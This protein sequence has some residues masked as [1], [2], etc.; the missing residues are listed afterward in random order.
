[1]KFSMAGILA[2]A[3]VL[4]AISPASAQTATPTP[5]LQEVDYGDD[6][7]GME[8]NAAHPDYQKAVSEYTDMIEHKL[9]RMV[10]KRG[11]SVEITP[12][13][14]AEIEELR[15]FWKEE[16]PDKLIDETDDTVFYVTFICFGSNE[17][18]EELLA[19]IMQR[20]QP[21]RED[22]ELTKVA[23]RG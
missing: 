11:V 6:E 15:A 1:M 5:P 16:N 3:A 18:S 21:T 2:A 22:V 17:D 19:A 23:F 4:I 8:P 12:E 9:R 7:K 20:S 10:I 14:K 13:I